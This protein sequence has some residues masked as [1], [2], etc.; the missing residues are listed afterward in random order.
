MNNFKSSRLEAQ[1][2]QSKP[3]AAYRLLQIQRVF[4]S[5]GNNF[6]ASHRHIF[7][8]KHA[9]RGR[10]GVSVATKSTTSSRTDRNFAKQ[11]QTEKAI[12]RL[13]LP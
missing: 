1:Q 6:P 5:A 2:M 4:V 12:C 7:D 11:M 13:Q 3:F 10:L 9:A 8:T